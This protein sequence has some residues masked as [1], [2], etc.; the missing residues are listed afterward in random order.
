[1][2]PDSQPLSP[3]ITHGGFPLSTV[4][5]RLPT[6]HA[7]NFNRRHR[8]SDRLFQ[9]RCKF[10]LCQEDTYLLELVRYIHLN[11]IR[12]KIVTDIKALDKYPFCGH[13]VIVGKKG[14]DWQDDDYG[15]KLFDRKKSSAQ[16][17]YRIF[18]EKGIKDV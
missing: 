17:G 1:M 4:M 2:G 13:A 15:L 3:F 18:V 9:N 12:A 14:K 7:M 11:P 6:G 8:R 16:R 10:I 5:R